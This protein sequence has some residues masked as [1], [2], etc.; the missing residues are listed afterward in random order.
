MYRDGQLVASLGAGASVGE[1]AYLAPNPE[2]ATHSADVTVTEP[3][4][5]ISFSPDTI[6]QMSLATR[7]L[8]DAAFLKVLVRRLH[9]AWQVY[10]RIPKAGSA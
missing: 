1:M 2:L 8:F 6:R 10:D 4:T 3:S 5:M 9:A 7:S